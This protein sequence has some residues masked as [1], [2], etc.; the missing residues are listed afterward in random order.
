M[1]EHG[2][3]LATW[4]M[5][6]PPEDVRV[7]GIQCVRLA[8]H[9]RRYLDYEGPI[10]GDCGHVARHDEGAC[11][12]HQRSGTAWRVAFR[13]RCLDGV[14]LLEKEGQGTAWRLRLL[15]P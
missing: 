11:R 8:D 9:R 1:I 13:G 12:V 4:K 14:F 10:S 15:S 7:G 2:S 5:D 3:T 6:T